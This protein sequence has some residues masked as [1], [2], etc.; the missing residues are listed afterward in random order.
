MKKAIVC[1]TRFGQ[2]YI[3]AL[4]KMPDVEVIGILA[5]G[6]QRSKRCAEKYN[7]KLYQT[8]EN[9]PD[10]I[11]FA[12]VIVKSEIMGGDGVK[13][14]KKLMEKGIDVLFE[15]PINISEVAQCFQTSQKY[16]KK[17]ALGN[18]YAKLPAVENFINNAQILINSS[19]PLFINVD[20][21]TQVS[22]PLMEILDRI[23][24]LNSMTVLKGKIVNANPFQVVITDEDG[25][26][27][28]YRGHNEVDYKD[29][30][31]YLHLFFQISIGFPSGRLTLIDPHGPVIWQPR[32]HFPK[33]DLIPLSLKNAPPEVMKEANVCYLYDMNNSQKKIFTDIWPDTI[34][35]D[36]SSFLNLIYFEDKKIEAKRIQKQLLWCRKWRDLM[37]HFGYPMIVETNKYS[38]ISNRILQRECIN[39]ES[40]VQVS[41]KKLNKACCYT[42][43]FYL[44][45]NVEMINPLKAYQIKNIIKGL[46][47]QPG[48]IN[49]ILRW[50]K[51]LHA[52]QYI[53]TNE[54]ECYFD[55]G[56]INWEEV[57]QAWEEANNKWSE[58][59]GTKAVF[60]YFFENAKQLGRIM[61]GEINPT[62]LLFP[63]GRFDIATELYSETAI[64]KELNHVIAQKVN[65]IANGKVVTILEL[66]A[67]T[68]ATTQ[69]IYKEIDN[70]NA[71]VDYIFSDLSEF[72]LNNAREKFAEQLR[73]RFEKIDIDNVWV[74]AKKIAIPQ[75]DIVV[76]VG[77]INNAKNILKTMRNIYK[78]LREEGYVFLVEAIGE[79]A[80]MLIS[81][82]FMMQE[83][84]DERKEENLT[85][86]FTE[87]WYNIF[88]KS[89]FK[90]IDR[91]PDGNSC[92]TMFNQRL[93][94]LQ[95]EHGYV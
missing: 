37:H 21:A 85:F 76:A 65:T 46:N 72:F 45:K 9:L 32:V 42:M 11:N 31:G 67:G 6:S 40:D 58:N 8:V 4:L 95:K 39:K 14:A 55:T 64:A 35:K 66:G 36:I 23:I 54:K 5:N 10:D 94:V 43:L 60:Q 20:F 52:E 34:K 50:I 24:S 27:I 82:A 51:F 29:S 91:L 59:L 7:L 53:F 1:G 84:N 92:L 3:E 56:K 17:F 88:A 77:V 80:P 30:D 89:G 13:I 15:Q 87:Q 28:V 48:F 75:V 71:T 22:Y 18:L 49:I 57:S 69:E 26:E 74:D 2:F 83:T 62:W 19:A 90:A 16:N 38:Y 86:L 68:G 81:Q 73:M 25:L 33:E 79:S 47:I 78:L 93:F 44:Q 63:E 70:K 41:F 61:S 12:C